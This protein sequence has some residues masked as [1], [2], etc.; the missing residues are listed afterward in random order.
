MDDFVDASEGIPRPLTQGQRRILSDLYPN[1]KIHDAIILLHG[2]RI[3]MFFS[4]IEGDS[5][6]SAA[7]DLVLTTLGKK[8][9]EE[10]ALIEEIK[11]LQSLVARTDRMLVRAQEGRRKIEETL[12]TMTTITVE[13]QKCETNA[14]GKKRKSGE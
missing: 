8:T 3:E 10:G 1:N 13:N 14:K 7:I 2:H 9:S 6:V 11:R 4:D 12:E 5:D